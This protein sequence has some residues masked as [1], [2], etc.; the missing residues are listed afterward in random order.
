LIL[1]SREEELA[2]KIP[3]DRFA[4]LAKRVAEE[5]VTTSDTD[6]ANLA[7]RDLRGNPFSSVAMAYPYQKRK[8]ASIGLADC[9]A[10]LILGRRAW[11]SDK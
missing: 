11:L 9:T 8:D 10:R 1:E 4:F 2:A 7:V 3:R 6:A 5:N